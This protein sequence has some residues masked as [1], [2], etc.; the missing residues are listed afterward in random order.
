VW[1]RRLGEPG[2][3]LLP[4]RGFLGITF[5]YA[6]LQKLA[7]PSFLDPL[8]PTSIASQMRA[9]QNTSPIGPLLAASAHMP[10]LV[11]LAIA[12]GELA[13]GV[14]A[15]LGLYLR[16]AAAA[17]A[18]LA[19]TFF[20]TVSWA[21]TPYFYGADIVF[22]FAWLTLLGFGDRGVFS[23]QAWLGDRARASLHLGPRPA[24]V[25]VSA[26]RLHTLC[27]RGGGCGLGPDGICH[28]SRGCPVFPTTEHIPSPTQHELDR[29]SALRT[30]GV[31]AVT[32]GGVAVLAGLTA[33]L[34]RLAGGGRPSPAP[35]ALSAS[36]AT[37]PTASSTPPPSSSVS[38]PGSRS[39]ASGPPSGRTVAPTTS[40]PPA[41]SASGPGVVIGAAS[42]V[43][44]G[45]G[46]SFTDP[47]TGDPAWVV[48][49]SG[50]HFIA[51]DAVCTHAGCTVEY[52]PTA[53][54]FRCPC[55]GGVFDA[56]TGQVLQGPPPSPLRGIP[57]QVTDGQLRVDT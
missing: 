14:G 18:L 16:I 15:L 45:Q 52:D 36:S 48:H 46:R 19:L 11:G 42:A 37:S 30:G 13:V 5:V 54:Q 26:E 28:R 8:S 33:W 32:A 38:P 51:F 21:T 10:V 4:L 25:A 29:R 47:A 1:S 3:V 34:G 7:N 20:L 31:A 57:V 22:V 17:G 9:L 56:L 24:T 55:H 41:A 44:L 27:P 39:S 12:F 53:V 49:P 43:P 2:W 40:G 6:G 35:I 23:L 50:S